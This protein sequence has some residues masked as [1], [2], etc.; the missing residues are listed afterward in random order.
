MTRVLVTGAGGFIGQELC[1]VLGD[2]EFDIVP[3]YRNSKS[4][5]EGCG[6]ATRICR[7]VGPATNW[8]ELLAGVEVVVH[9]VGKT[10]SAGG[11]SSD[12]SEEFRR[13]NV[14]GTVELA[15]QAAAAGVKRF[16]YLSSIKVN[17][18]RTTG[19]PFTADGAP[20]PEDVY[21]ETKLEAEIALRRIEAD[22]GL[23]VVIIRP[24]LVY[25]QGVKGNLRALAK[26]VD[27]GV[28]LPIGAIEN[29]RSLVSLY[30]L[31]DLIRLC[32]SSP[33]AEGQTF[34][35]SDAKD[36]STT[37]LVGYIADGLGK[38]VRILS[39]PLWVL[40]GAAGLFGK[41]HAVEKLTEDL[42]VDMTNTQETLSWNPP[43][44]ISESF[45]MM[46]E[47]GNSG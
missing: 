23:E 32:I 34:L 45:R 17:G 37:E 28:P 43:H 9:L 31:C 46:F 2:P 21:G 47:D 29:R 24:P 14:G 42:Q 8:G 1:N 6:K 30:N 41:R 36:L 33:A 39:V 40:K 4:D 5:G 20:E 38:K 35:V 12:E 44:S 18:E 22:A 7:D 16:V 15:G 26:I 19:S 10:H 25:G 11:N 27:K 3:V 13:V